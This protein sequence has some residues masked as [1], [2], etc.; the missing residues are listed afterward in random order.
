MD[1]DEREARLRARL[2]AG[3]RRV[4]A[5]TPGSPEWDAALAAIDALEGQLKALRPPPAATSAHVVSRLGP[6]VLEDGCAV[7]GIVAAPGPAGEALRF[8]ISR[9]PDRA[10]SRQ[11][12]TEEVEAL[13]RRAGFVL[14]IEGDALELSFYAWD[15]EVDAPGAPA[16]S[17]DTPAP[18]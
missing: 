7:Q 13:V 10:R 8:E 16:P 17:A 12:F 11:E 1:T 6:M 5:A 2:E 18:G 14:E 3:Y 9:I 15:P 4:E